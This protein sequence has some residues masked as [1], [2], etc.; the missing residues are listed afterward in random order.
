MSHALQALRAIVMRELMKFA[1]QYGRLVSALV[2]PLLWL[3]NGMPFV[4]AEGLG[5]W[6]G[7]ARKDAEGAAGV[8]HGPALR[9]WVTTPPCCRCGCHCCRPQ[10]SVTAPAALWRSR[11]KT[12]GSH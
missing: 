9:G 2:R 3:A 8:G 4:P 12:P 5:L 11:T 1:R 6:P 7:A 10:Q